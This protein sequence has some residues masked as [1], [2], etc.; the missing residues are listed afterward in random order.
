MGHGANCQEKGTGFRRNHLQGVDF[1]LLTVLV[2]VPRRIVSVW[3][4]LTT[5]VVGG[6]V[7]PTL[8]RVHHSME[9]LSLLTEPCHS[10]DVHEAN[11]LQWTKGTL[12]ADALDCTLC[13][14]RLLSVPSASEKAVAPLRFGS[15]R[16]GVESHLLAA[17]VFTD[18]TIRGPPVVA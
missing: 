4:L 15:P 9:R 14:V 2:S 3:L 16:T 6:L 7:G 8:H 11:S 13:T 18:R 12:A 17:P 10:P 1:V 5:F